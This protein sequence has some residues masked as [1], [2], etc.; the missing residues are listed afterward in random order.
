LVAQATAPP[1]EWGAILHARSA[2]SAPL[3]GVATVPD[4]LGG[5]GPPLG[6][7]VPPQV[8]APF[9]PTRRDRARC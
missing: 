8:P 4:A 1:E 2:R 7:A 9:P 3:A 6:G 5:G